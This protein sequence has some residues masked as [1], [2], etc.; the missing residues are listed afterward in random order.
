VTGGQQEQQQGEGEDVDMA[1][2]MGFEEVQQEAAAKQRAFESQ[3]AKA[4]TSG[5]SGQGTGLPSLVDWMHAC[6]GFMVPAVITRC[7]LSL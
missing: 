3:Q 5:G 2:Q 6:W 4:S 7:W 1:G